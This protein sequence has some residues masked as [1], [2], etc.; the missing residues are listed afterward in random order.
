MIA[1]ADVLGESLAEYAPHLWQAAQH[2][3][4]ASSERDAMHVLAM[5]T[6]A[7]E[8]ALPFDRAVLEKSTRLVAV[9]CAC[10]WQDL[11]TPQ[12]F[13]AHAGLPLPPER[14]YY[15]WGYTELIGTAAHTLSKRLTLYPGCRI[16][17]QRHRERDEHWSIMEGAA[18]VTLDDTA[19]RLQPGD[20]VLVPRG[21]WH[22]IENVGATLLH[23]HEVQAGEPD[24][25]DIE[26][27]E[28]DYGR[29]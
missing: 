28:D 1:R 8:H 15:P 3:V 19:L 14:H 20:A 23:V 11:G 16:S 9:A 2:A 4:T 22:R 24:E 5:V 27:A 10:G 13:A 17:L 12:A 25:R 29:A 26:R 7:A 6:L 18:Q 21:V